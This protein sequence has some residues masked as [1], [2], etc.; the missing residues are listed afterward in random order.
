MIKMK[1]YKLSEL[2]VYAVQYYERELQSSEDEAEIE[3]EIA[4]QR[5]E[6]E[7]DD[8]QDRYNESDTGRVKLPL[9]ITLLKQFL[10]KDRERQDPTIGNQRAAS[11]IKISNKKKPGNSYKVIYDREI[12]WQETAVFFIRFH[13]KNN[14]MG[15]SHIIP[16]DYS[17]N[18]ENE[19]LNMTSITPGMPN[20][21]MVISNEEICNIIYEAPKKLAGHFLGIETV[22]KVTFFA[23]NNLEH[24]GLIISNSNKSL[25]QSNSI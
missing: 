5:D 21:M 22:N 10:L 4:S 20:Q 23:T 8:T 16:I 6:V 11:Y 13:A 9:P 25:L 18:I 12:I 24:H 3:Q 7:K 19:V 1:E 15:M 17:L 2:L 14:C